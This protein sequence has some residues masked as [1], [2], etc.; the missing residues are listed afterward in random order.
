[1]T[2]AASRPIGRT[3]SSA[4]RASMPWAVAM[5]TSSAPVETSTQASSSLSSIVIARMPVDRTRSN[6]SSGV[7]LMMPSPGRH[8]EV[9]AG[10]E[11]RQD[12]RRHRDLAGLDLDAGQV[13]DRGALGLAA[14]VGD[15]VDLG[16]EDAAAVREEQRPV[17]GVGDDQVLDR[18][19]LA[20]DVAD[21]ALAAAVLAAVGRDRLALDVAAAARS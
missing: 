13:D 11:V 14:G 2:P 18:V 7:F 8:D 5:M 19:L 9:V 6:C 20:G 4:N 21:D 10:L 1:M 17:V 3:S 15:R 12:D 16:A